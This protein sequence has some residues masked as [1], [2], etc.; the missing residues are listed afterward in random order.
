MPRRP[1]GRHRGG[2][3]GN[4][5]RL[6]HGLYAKKLPLEQELRL[7]ALGLNRHH[8][9]IPLA[10]TRLNRLLTKQAASSDRDFLT[11]EC[12]IMYYINLI[13]RLIHRNKRLR[14]RTGIPSADLVAVVDKLRGL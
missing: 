7:E 8:L 4:H 5:N 10:R 11:Y 1:S 2:Q 9:T 14:A 6:T 13:A 3:P 12:A